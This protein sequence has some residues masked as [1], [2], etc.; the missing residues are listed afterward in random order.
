MARIV[1]YMETPEQGEYVKFAKI[2]DTLQELVETNDLAG[3]F[4]LTLDEKPC[5][6]EDHRPDLAQ[7]ANDVAAAQGFPVD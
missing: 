3:Y 2:C 4:T 6:Q 7:L 1:M 5:L